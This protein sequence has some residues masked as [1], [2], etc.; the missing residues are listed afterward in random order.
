MIKLKE[1]VKKEL[2][3]FD[4]HVRYLIKRF[5]ELNMPEKIK[6]LKSISKN[7]EPYS[8]ILKYLNHFY[9]TDSE[10][11]IKAYFSQI[12]MALILEDLYPDILEKHK[13]GIRKNLT[14]TQNPE[15][16]FK[17]LNDKNNIIRNII[18]YYDSIPEIKELLHPSTLNGPNYI[19]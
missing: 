2:D 1:I 16:D 13:R 10:P 7:T 17:V 5:K 3:D 11:I 14:P 4:A 6:E 8:T 12:L 9:E 18:F 15:E 19:R